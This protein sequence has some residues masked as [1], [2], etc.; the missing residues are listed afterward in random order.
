MARRI[1]RGQTICAVAST[2]VQDE[3]LTGLTGADNNALQVVGLQLLLPDETGVDNLSEFLLAY[4]VDV[5]LGEQLGNVI[6]EF[7]RNVILTTSGLT[8]FDRNV[9]LDLSA[10]Q[11]LIF[12]QSIFFNFAATIPGA[13]SYRLIVDEVKI[14]DSQKIGILALLA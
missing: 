1:I 14:T 11:M 7:S 6:A 12:Q 8:A 3:V 9:Y 4:G 10:Q 13:I 5:T 2:N